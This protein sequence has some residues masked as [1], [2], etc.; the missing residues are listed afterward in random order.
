MIFMVETGP[1]ISKTKEMLEATKVKIFRKV[2]GKTLIDRKRRR[3]KKIFNRMDDEYDQ[4]NLHWALEG[5]DVHGKD[6]VTILI[7]RKKRRYTGRRIF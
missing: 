5:L 2:S 3:N 6:G 7:M 1:E 4:T